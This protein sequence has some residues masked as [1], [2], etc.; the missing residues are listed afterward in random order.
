MKELHRPW[1]NWHSEVANIPREAIPS[2][3]LRDSALF[4]QRSGANVLELILRGWVNSTIEAR[5]SELLRNSSLT[6]APNLVRPLFETTTV[7]LGSSNR[8]SDSN[9]PTLDLPMNFFVNADLLGDILRLPAFLS[10]PVPQVRRDFYAATLAR[11]DFRLASGPT[12]DAATFCLKGDT[13]FAFFVPVPSFG[14]TN[15]IRQLIARN[16][17]TPHFALSVLM[18]DFPN[19]VYSA[20]RSRLL[21]YVPSTAAVQDGR[22]DLPEKTAAAI[23]QAAATQPPDSPESRFAANWA[24]TPD[25][26]RADADTRVKSYLEAVRNRLATQTGFD[27]YTR[28][29]QSR[30]ERFATTPLREQFPFMLPRTNI[31]AASLHM[32]AD[33]TVKP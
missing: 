6:D 4:R 27:D 30:R 17:I 21:R 26:L 10:V 25:Q 29:A 20:P 5:V 14:D 1:N 28:L 32:N 11:F 18:V 33:G 22:S 9:T 16:V 8:S 19:P 23:V 24:L 7:N 12:C 31:P 15:T 3:E 13:H 2:P